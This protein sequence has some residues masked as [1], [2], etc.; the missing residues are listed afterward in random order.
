MTSPSSNGRI[1]ILETVLLF[2]AML[3]PLW[4]PGPFATF[5]GPQHAF[6]G[7]VLNHHDDA[8]TAFCW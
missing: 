1:T 3:V 4:V 7:Y 8:G 2:V 6:A 5:D